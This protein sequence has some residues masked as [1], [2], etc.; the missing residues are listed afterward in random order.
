M[1]KLKD[2]ISEKKLQIR[3]LEQHMIGSFEMTP[4]TNSIELSQVYLVAL[5]GRHHC[6]NFLSSIKCPSKVFSI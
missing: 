2:G 6:H 3:I 5:I 4:H 1:R